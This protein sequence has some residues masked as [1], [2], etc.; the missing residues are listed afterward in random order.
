VS[1]TWAIIPIKRFERA[2]SRLALALPRDARRALAQALYAR[3]RAACLACAERGVIA[4]VLIATD[5]PDI[6][7]RASA[8]P[9][10]EA[11]LDAQPSHGFARVIDRALAYAHE[12]GATQAVVV[13]ADLP[14]VTASDVAELVAALDHAPLVLSPDQNRRGIGALACALP[15]P[16]AMQLGRADSFDRHLR[17]ARAQRIAHRVL[18]N[19]RLAHDVDTIDDLCALTPTAASPR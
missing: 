16:I 10:C 2:K 3:T 7:R 8:H 6:A 11:L 13:M 19:P 17:V 15:A 1:G 14:Q 5:A 9:T 4:R 12:H 18:S